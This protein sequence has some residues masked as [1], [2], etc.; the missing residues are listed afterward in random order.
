[1]KKQR[2]DILSTDPLYEG[3]TLQT[4]GI[5]HLHDLCRQAIERCRQVVEP[6][7]QR[8]INLKSQRPL[9][10]KEEVEWL[11]EALDVWFT[12]KWNDKRGAAARKMESPK[13]RKSNVCIQCQKSLHC[14]DWDGIEPKVFP[15]LM[16]PSERIACKDGS[17]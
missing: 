13:K 1:M 5:D 4:L 10:K 3:E 9:Q 8:Y 11:T 14:V 12:K 17:W 15:P 7:G 6:L 2:D 16:S